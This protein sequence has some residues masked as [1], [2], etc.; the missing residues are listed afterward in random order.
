MF[1]TVLSN[2]NYA[3]QSQGNQYKDLNV[4]SKLGNKEN[5]KDEVIQIRRPEEFVDAYSRLKNLDQVDGTAKALGWLQDK[6]Y[7]VGPI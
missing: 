6:Y 1:S 7:F 4:G 5:I 2:Q 3:V